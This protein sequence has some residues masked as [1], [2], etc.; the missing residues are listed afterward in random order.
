MVAKTSKG[1]LRVTH[2]YPS[3]TNRTR[4]Y[5]LLITSSDAFP[6][7]YRRL[8]GAHGTNSLLT[9]KIWHMRN[10][11]NVMVYFTPGKYRRVMYFSVGVHRTCMH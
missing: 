7:S 1:V 6:L 2:A 4:T 5:D 8:V 10:K 11:I 9:A 3:S